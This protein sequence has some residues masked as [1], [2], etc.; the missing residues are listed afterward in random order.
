MGRKLI[1]QGIWLIAMLVLLPTAA[2]AQSVFA[3]TVKDTS[4]A[5]MPG[6]TVEVSSPALIEGVRT[7]VTSEADS[8]ASS[9]SGPARIS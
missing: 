7:A 6:V 5:V 4:G 3:G 8:T 9:T 2:R 1:V